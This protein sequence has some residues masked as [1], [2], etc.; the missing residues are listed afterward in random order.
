MKRRDFMEMFVATPLALKVTEPLKQELM[1]P[2][3]PG[4]VDE[5]Y[6]GEPEYLDPDEILIKVEQDVCT[7]M[8]DTIDVHQQEQDK[9]YRFDPPD[10]WHGRGVWTVSTK[11]GE[12][13]LVNNDGWAVRPLAIL[14][15]EKPL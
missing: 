1:E 2:K 10:L 15:K 3:D 12:V 9:T 5:V 13:R 11:D 6:D 14:D 8:G 7:G 4:L